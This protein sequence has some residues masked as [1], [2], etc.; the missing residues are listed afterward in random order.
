[1]QMNFRSPPCPQ[2]KDP[3]EIGEWLSKV[4]MAVCFKARAASLVPGL[5]HPGSDKPHTCWHWPFL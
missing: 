5:P 2:D 3:A 1:M 4:I